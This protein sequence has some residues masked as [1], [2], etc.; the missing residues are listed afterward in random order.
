MEIDAI[1]DRFT[2]ACNVKLPQ[3]NFYTPSNREFYQSNPY[4]DLDFSKHEIRL[5]ELLP[6]KDDK[7]LNV[8]LT[9][10][11]LLSSDS[12]PRATALFLTLLE[13]IRKPK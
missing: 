5:L 13:N 2:G 9:T 4:S 1:S 10:R 8:K 7:P 6:V 12:T 3:D 11:Y